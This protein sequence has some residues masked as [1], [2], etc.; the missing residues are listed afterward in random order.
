MQRIRAWMTEALALARDAGEVGEV[1]V[2]ALVIGPDGQV[3]ARAGNARVGTNARDTHV[4]DG[5]PVTG[6]RPADAATP[7]PTA[8]AEIRA[9]RAAAAALGTAR[10]DG[11]TLVVTLEPCVMCAGAA[12]QA[13]LGRI[14]FGAWDEKAG[15]VGGRL[16][17]VRDGGLPH[18]VEVVAGVLA[19]E[20]AEQ[21]RAFFES[22]R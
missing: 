16:D 12:L 6:S 13:R 11:C 17:V 14:V 18:S 7:D 4:S 21:L 20:A 10:L 2:G 19:D 22:R 9:I 8:H 15:A 5:A 1:P 3:L